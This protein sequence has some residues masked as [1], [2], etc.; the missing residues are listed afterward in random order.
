MTIHTCSYSQQVNLPIRRGVPLP[1]LLCPGCSKL[2]RRPMVP[3]CTGVRITELRPGVLAGTL[4]RGGKVSPTI[5]LEENASALD[6]LDDNL[7]PFVRVEDSLSPFVRVEDS[8]SP[9]VRVEDSLSPFA[10][11][12]DGLSPFA[13]AEENR[14]PFD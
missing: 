10:R 1:A 6:R 12:K 8:L 3:S 5:L 7:S 13:R 4:E 9:F 2:L 14:S 11:V